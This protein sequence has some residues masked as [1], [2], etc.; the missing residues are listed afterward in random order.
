M[1]VKQET[2]FIL[3][4]SDLIIEVLRHS[5][6]QNFACIAYSIINL[7]GYFHSVRND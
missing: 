6:E 3:F 2:S 5:N 7:T 1:R 4:S